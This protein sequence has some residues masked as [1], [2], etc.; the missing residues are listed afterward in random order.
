MVARGWTEAKKRA[1]VIA[2]N[3][4]ALNAGM[5]TK[6]LLGGELAICGPRRRPQPGRLLGRGIASILANVGDGLTDPDDVPEP[7]AEPVSKAGDVGCSAGIVWS[8]AIALIAARR[9][10]AGGRPDRT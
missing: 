9:T 1:Y 6:A 3:K 7:P 2:D 5:E 10:G 4:L 8:A